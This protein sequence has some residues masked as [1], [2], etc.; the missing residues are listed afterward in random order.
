VGSG[1]NLA[2]RNISATRGYRDP[3]V[4]P[5]PSHCTDFTTSKFQIKILFALFSAIRPNCLP[6]V[7]G[8]IGDGEIFEWESEEMRVFEGNK[9]VCGWKM[10]DGVDG[11]KCA[12]SR[13]G[14]GS[15]TGRGEAKRRNVRRRQLAQLRRRKLITDRGSCN[16]CRQTVHRRLSWPSQQKLSAVCKR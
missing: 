6:R 8:W 16:V 1:A 3:V 2:K 13:S 4:Q 14:D 12:G 10:G 11:G 7:G 9:G 15:V 5:S